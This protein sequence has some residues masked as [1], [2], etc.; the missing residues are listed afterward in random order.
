[1]TGYTVAKDTLK[2][3]KSSVDNLDK[4]Y[5]EAHKNCLGFKTK[6]TTCSKFKKNIKE[7]IKKSLC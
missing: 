7:A 6:D 5:A 1:M 3:N 4:K 2:V